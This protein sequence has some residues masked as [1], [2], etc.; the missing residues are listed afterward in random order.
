MSGPAPAAQGP[1]RGPLVERGLAAP[2]LLAVLAYARVLGGEFQFDDLTS[3]EENP[4]VKAPALLLAKPLLDGAFRPL[5]DLTFALNHALGRLDP[6]GY[7]LV[8]LALHLVAVVLV[9]R[10][11]LAVLR[12]AGAAGVEGTALAVAGV[13]AVHPLHAQAV[14]YVSQRAEI[15]SSVLYLGALLLLLEADGRGRGAAAVAAWGGALAAWLLGLHAKAVAVTLPAAWVLLAATLP[16]GEEPVP[17]RLGRALIQ[18]APFLAVAALFAARTAGSL[19]GRPD[20][21]LEVPGIPPLAYGLTQLR[22]VLG[23]LRLLAWPSGL[24]LDHEVA[25]SRGLDGPTLL[26]AA[27]LVGLFGAAAALAVRSRAWPAPERA[28]AR[29]GLFGLGWFLLILAPTSGAIPLVDLM[30]EHRAYLAS[31]GPLLAAGAGAARLLDRLPRA[32]RRILAIGGVAALWLGLA[33]ALHARNA[34]WETKQALWTDVVAKSP[35]KVRAHLNLGHAFAAEGAHQAAVESYRRALALPPDATATRTEILR[36]LGAALVAMGRLEEAS[37]VLRQ[38]LEADPRDPEL[39]NNLAICLLDLQDPAG[40]EREA[41]RA[42]ESDPHSGPALNTLGEALLT[43]GNLDGAL[44]SFERA[45]S[46]DPDV[47]LRHHNAAVV[48][49]RLGR[50]EEACRAAARSLAAERS[51]QGREEARQFALQLGC[52]R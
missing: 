2:L 44:A 48:L 49:A 38:A 47:A 43:Q 40:A 4:A 31:W 13:F 34:V 25:L 30:E 28:A 52:A 33:L 35:G 22:V 10:L 45:V 36:N 18:V 5:T 41:R 46:I 29:L 32:R 1:S 11:S 15:L 7:H 19:R 51:A 3:V 39:R 9:H 27:A 37:R 21:G 26:S 12:R 42:L 50:T 14:S 16:R 8:N 24:N 17:R 20:A 23:Y 6:F